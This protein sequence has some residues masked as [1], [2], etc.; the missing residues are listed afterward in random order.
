MTDIAHGGHDL[1]LK[2][3]Y[4]V[5]ST[6]FHLIHSVASSTEECGHV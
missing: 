4:A 6:R 3:G 2:A 1:G 5:V